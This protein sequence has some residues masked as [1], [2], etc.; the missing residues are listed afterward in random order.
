MGT[1]FLAAGMLGVDS[2]MLANAIRSGKLMQF[3]TGRITDVAR[4]GGDVVKYS[5]AGIR[6]VEKLA[7]QIGKLMPLIANLPKK[8]KIAAIFALTL[9]GSTYAYAKSH[10]DIEKQLIKDGFW[11]ARSENITPK[12]KER[13]AKMTDDEKRTFMDGLF[14]TFIE[15]KETLP[16]TDS[17]FEKGVYTLITPKSADMG[18]VWDSLNAHET[19]FGEELR[20]LGIALNVAAKDA[21]PKQKA[22]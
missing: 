21:A 12:L 3:A 8:L 13:F 22:A 19:K 4:F 18:K 7:P 9:G 15:N 20:T 10:T 2:V 17:H 11:D 16:D 5:R 14:V 6:G 1:G